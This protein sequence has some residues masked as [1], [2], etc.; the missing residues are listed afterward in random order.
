ME[1]NILVYAPSLDTFRS[2][3]CGW[4]LVIPPTFSQ[5]L[6]Q[7]EDVNGD[8]MGGIYQLRQPGHGIG[9]WIQLA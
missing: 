1:D 7:R 6:P 2:L 4:H 8:L 5:I 9:G 3:V